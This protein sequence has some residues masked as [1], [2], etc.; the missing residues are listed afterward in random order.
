M[1]SVKAKVKKMVGGEKLQG[2]QPDPVSRPGPMSKSSGMGSKIAMADEP[3]PHMWS[4]MGKAEKSGNMKL[5]P[6]EA[7]GPHS[8]AAPKASG[9]SSGMKVSMAELGA[10]DSEEKAEIGLGAASDMAKKRPLKKG[11]SKY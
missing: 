6:M 9:E 2:Q 11:A 10:D 4:P 7:P 3:G 1:K 8:Y 5:N